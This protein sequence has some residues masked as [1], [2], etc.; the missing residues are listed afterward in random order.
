L[1]S[2]IFTAKEAWTICN[3]PLSPLQPRDLLIWRC[4]TNGL[5]SVRSEYHME[6]DIQALR[7]G[8]CSQ[9][10]RVP[11][12]RRQYGALMFPMPS[13]CSFGEPVIIFFQQKKMYRRRVLPNM[14]C[15]ICCREDKM[16]V[17]ILWSCPYA[18]DVWGC[19]PSRLRKSSSL[20]ISFSFVFEELLGHCDTKVMSL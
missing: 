9:P 4:T 14:L 1:I 16:V 13:K 19:G 6:N 18:Q 7:K 11:K 17:P 20:G 5:F 12:S 2:T 3:I 15:H 8:G 10:Q